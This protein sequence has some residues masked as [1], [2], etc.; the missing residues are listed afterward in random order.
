[1]SSTRILLVDDE[2]HFANTMK[3]VLENRGYSVTALNSGDSA[4]ST[5]KED[6]N[7]DVMILDLKMPGMDGIAT[8]KELKKQNLSIK[9]LVLTGHGDI[10]TALEATKMGASDYLT[11]PCEIQELEEKLQKIGGETAGKKQSFLG[12]ILGKK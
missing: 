7:Y 8:L 10:G 5:L 9:T 2:V 3:K 12:K 6:S 11:K 1:M 4:V